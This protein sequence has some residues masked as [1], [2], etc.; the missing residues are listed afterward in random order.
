MRHWASCLL[1]L[2]VLVMEATRLP[3]GHA[4]ERDQATETVP[5][6][7][8]VT[9]PDNGREVTL[10]SGGSISVRLEAIPGTGYGWQL[11]RNGSPQLQLEGPARFE[12]RS[13]VEAGGVEDEVF[14][15]RA[16]MTGIAEIEFHYRRPWDKQGPA[17]KTFT[18][19][20]I[21]E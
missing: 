2:S 9:T 6:V 13:N 17:A 15:F 3:E 14:R 19:R 1:I 10:Q 12:P 20:I 16:Q 18:I 7:M 11:V 21:V 8:I 5:G 4:S